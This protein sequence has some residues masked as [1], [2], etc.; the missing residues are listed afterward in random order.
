[1]PQAYFL[2]P[3]ATQAGPV[4][5]RLFDAAYITTGIIDPNRLG[6]G[7]TGAGNL[8]LADDGTWK[9]VS[10]GGGGAVDR[11][12]A[13]TNISISPTG[14]TGVV[15]INATTLNPDPTGYGSFFSNQTQA[16]SVINTPQVVTFNNTYEAND[17]YLSSN[18]IYFNKAGTYQFAYI[19]Q[20]FNTANSIEHCS[21]WI[22]Y[23]GN[24]F[25][26][27]ATHITVNARKSSTE[28]SEQQMKLIL[29]GTAQNDGDYIE[30]YWQGTT[31]S[32]SLGYIAAG[33]GEAPVNSPS[34]IANI[35]P[36]GA[37]GRDS[38]LNELNDVTITSPVNNQL[39]RYNSGI[40]ENWT[41]NF[42]T[43]VPTLDQ[44]TTAGNTTTNAITIGGLN[45]INKDIGTNLH[46][47]TKPNFIQDGSSI[48]YAKNL[49]GSKGSFSGV[50]VDNVSGA[51]G[52]HFITSSA[53][54]NPDW[55]IGLSK[56]V[57]TWGDLFY[58]ADSLAA[59][60]VLTLTKATKNVL[61]GTT[62][63]AGYKLDVNGTARI[64]DVF[65]ITKPFQTGVR[66]RLLTA[67]VSD[68]SGDFFFINNG[69][70]GDGR[71]APAFGGIMNTTN[72]LFGL[73][74]Q[75][76]TT[77]ALDTAAGN[78]GLVDFGAMRT[79]NATDPL[80]G[81]LSNVVNRK[82]FTFRGLDASSTYLTIFSSGNVNIGNVLTD[83]GYKLDV[84]GT[85]RVQGEL[86]V[87]VPSGG[88]FVR[89]SLV[90]MSVADAPNDAF[91]IGN[92]TNGNNV[93]WPS[94]AGFGTNANRA[95][96]QFLGIVN[97]TSDVVG[98][99]ITSILNF[100]VAKIS[101]T[102]DPLNATRSSV[103][104]K[105][106]LTVVNNGAFYLRM[107][108]N[109]NLAIGTTTDNGYKLDV[110]G[111]TAVRGSLLVTDT[112]GTLRT[113]ISGFDNNE[114]AFNGTRW[115]PDASS[116]ITYS[117]GQ[118]TLGGSNPRILAGNQDIIITNVNGNVPN[119]YITL[120]GV[121]ATSIYSNRTRDIVLLT[122][123]TVIPSGSSNINYN[124]LS[125]SPSVDYSGVTGSS[126]FR[127]L[128]YAP[129][130]TGFVGEHE[131][132]RTAAGKVIHQGL[133]NATHSDV[134][135]YNS[136]TGELTYGALPTPA[137]PTLDAVT[138]AGNST[139]NGITVGASVIDGITI[140][141]SNS[142]G[143]KN[144]GIGFQ[145][146]LNSTTGFSNTA[147]G[148]RA[149]EATTTGLGNEFFGAEAGINNTT[150][151]ANVYLGGS[152]GY[153]EKTANYNVYIGNSAGG[154]FSD[155][156]STSGNN[157]AIGRLAGNNSSGGDNVFLG[158]SAGRNSTV[159]N[160]LIIGNRNNSSLLEGNFST[161]NILI[162]TSTDSGYK[163]DVNGDVRILGNLYM[164]DATNR[165][166][167]GI[168]GTYINLYNGG[169]GGMDF[170]SLGGNAESRF[171][172]GLRVTGN[173]ITQGSFSMSGN[174]DIGSNNF[175]GAV[176]NGIRLYRGF[177][178]S[179]QFYLGHPTVGDFLWDY[180]ENTT[181][182]VLKR[183]GNLGIGTT[184]P[185]D[186]L[187]VQGNSTVTGYL[188]VHGLL[189]HRS[190]FAVLN[191]A[192]GGWLFWANRNDSEAE[193]A[194]R[195]DYVRSING[196]AGGN[197]GIGTTTP[198]H[199]L[200]VVGDSFIQTQ[201]R[202]TNSAAGIKLVPSS[203]HNYEI[204]ATTSN[205]FLIYNRTTNQYNLFI[206]GGGYVGINTSS[207]THTL[208]VNGPGRFTGVLRADN[209]VD[210]YSSTA[211]HRLF[212]GSSVFAGGI[213][214]SNWTGRGG[215]D[216]DIYSVSNIAFQTNDTNVP[217]MF[218]NTTGNVG[219]GTTAPNSKLHIYG[220][221]QNWN[222]DIPGQTVGTIHLAPNS[223]ASDFGNAITFGAI[224][225]N[226]GGDAQAGIY[227]KASG[228]YGTKMY[229][230]TTNSFATG[231]RT[232]MMINNDG[233]VTI[234]TTVP[235]SVLTVNVGNGGAN[236]SGGV[237]IYGTGNYHSLE[238]GIEGNY[239]GM[240]RTYGNDLLLYG[241]HWRTVGAVA[242]G[243]HSIKFFTTKSGSADWSTAKMVLNHNG[244]LG[245]GTTNPG[246][247]LHVN[248]GD[249]SI[250]DSTS[251]TYFAPDTVY[252]RGAI[253]G[254]GSTISAEGTT[255]H[256][257]LLTSLSGATSKISI[258]YFKAGPGWYAAFHVDSSQTNP[259]VLLQ[260]EGNNVIIGGTTD[261]GDKLNVVGTVAATG[262]KI[263]GNVG[264]TGTIFIATN[265]PG[266]QNI[267][268]EGGLITGF[269]A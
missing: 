56:N 184:N 110:N 193:V 143:T 186:K 3:P 252:S 217:K 129:I 49:S 156:T 72:S 133:T 257:R 124:S 22:R 71:F 130:L 104:T 236:G 89:E 17:V 82:L 97:E 167:Y 218:I 112:A 58:M 95:G 131:A 68:A 47:Y 90:R 235:A 45:S 244:N 261:S 246:Y 161:G 15:T 36:I 64:N 213:G 116:N 192:A 157:V 248:N 111:N 201:I 165:T 258:G 85:A 100:E 67:S 266:Q 55:L 198:S 149:G 119:S 241:G 182:M 54:A 221:I 76:F 187:Y 214:L 141:D 42:L 171:F 200:E 189:Y 40:W 262:Y 250:G 99:G 150:G 185:T 53:S 223:N 178:A 120:R 242:S 125:I 73:S 225:W 176:S 4:K 62:T 209:A 260:P 83:T 60:V 268:V 39:L 148:Y 103:T 135:Y 35:I 77:S 14:G 28:P 204:Q 26:N 155:G 249:V 78:F 205:E 11:I 8:Y 139:T 34:V 132:I 101:G 166:I 43:S 127:G 19:A 202:S 269:G 243:D 247:K 32:L 181:L 169:T 137:T 102:S 230:A 105:S 121:G 88:S 87:N 174:L 118:L 5:W 226:S 232:R 222:A 224:D 245:I 59:S 267:T 219:I 122:M 253:M 33:P 9:P 216:I 259:A 215:S 264:W 52:G 151:F 190:S 61:I 191:K 69:T 23:N 7:A 128:Y 20:V 147:V 107:F 144:I 136:T 41:P 79:T 212:T 194:M 207:P 44:V 231:S 142:S 240:I 168:N 256:L 197:V 265:P 158:H 108:A 84:N 66:E 10:G 203:G 183:G 74:F 96:I 38:N 31:T 196:T 80:N 239:D 229:F 160:R 25:P 57:G 195:L 51:F 6:T 1:M 106:V 227:V 46:L 159:S 199:K 251:Q 115:V 86:T 27:S 238:M 48:V 263:N 233:R 93:F 114:I 29:S 13:G 162:G 208:D 98:D 21:F 117:N 63:D 70:I 255:R 234:N 175:V 170:Y 91:F 75:G 188:G 146:L 177:D 37:Q 134:V 254:L 138:T 2:V 153:F 228:A 172:G 113:A 152:A 140:W 65:T 220:G 237:T 179:M 206:T 50:V 30:L 81:T 154:G 145:T 180:P 24:N 211:S 16:I 12:I 126:I 173:L 164:N 123:S 94:F 163:L 109:G 92:G 18:R 210:S